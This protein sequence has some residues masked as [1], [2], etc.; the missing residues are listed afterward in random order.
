M[1]LSIIP[2]LCPFFQLP[3]VFFFLLSVPRLTWLLSP[4][5]GEFL[6]PCKL[7]SCSTQTLYFYFPFSPETN[8][9]ISLGENKRA[10]SLASRLQWSLVQHNFM[11]GSR[12]GSRLCIPDILWAGCRKLG[13]GMLGFLTAIFWA[14][15]ITNYNGSFSPTHPNCWLGSQFQAPDTPYTNRQRSPAKKKKGK[16]GGEARGIGMGVKKTPSKRA[17]AAWLYPAARLPRKRFPGCAV[18]QFSHLSITSA[19][20]GS[21]TLLPSA[22]PAQSSFQQQQQQRLSLC[23]SSSPGSFHGCF[24][25]EE[26]P[27]LWSP[28]PN[29]HLVLLEIQIHSTAK[30]SW[31][32]F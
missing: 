26:N 7:H 9:I 27:K 24:G 29:K 5:S 14:H 32:I 21:L 28:H 15:K 8:N 13:W 2:Y 6:K 31:G 18:S 11:A 19:L 30:P 25:L 22:A 10:P 4:V 1:K 12:L 16:A 20:L 17:A 3:N 23:F